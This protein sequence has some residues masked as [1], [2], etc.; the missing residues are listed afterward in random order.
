[1]KWE[2][3]EPGDVIGI[4]DE[5]IN[6]NTNWLCWLEKYYKKELVVYKVSKMYYEND[7]YINIYGGIVL[8]KE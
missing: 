7:E 3:L 5:A 1:M 8:N 2:D 4:T 6:Y